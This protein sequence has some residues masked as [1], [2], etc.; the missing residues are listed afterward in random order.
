[1]LFSC[2]DDTSEPPA[3]L[4]G[5]IPSNLAF[6]SEL[7]FVPTPRPV[8]PEFFSSLSELPS[9]SLPPVHPEF[10]S[11][12]LASPS[13]SPV[14]Q[15]PSFTNIE[16]E[17]SPQPACIDP[18]LLNITP[19]VPAA[20]INLTSSPDATNLPGI[21]HPGATDEG[22]NVGNLHDFVFKKI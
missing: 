4:P 14:P 6:S 2:Q 1:M 5:S 15:V 18:S 8:T 22:S 21:Q 20:N 13:P 17:Y 9:P 3:M 7:D 19:S 11:N 10:Y 12:E 16:A